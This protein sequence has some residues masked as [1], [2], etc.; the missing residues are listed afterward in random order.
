MP[1]LIHGKG[2]KADIQ[3][4]SSHLLGKRGWDPLKCIHK[5]TWGESWQ[6][7][8]LHKVFFN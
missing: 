2:D 1:A 3:L 8:G 4:L 5:Q 6:C 7:E